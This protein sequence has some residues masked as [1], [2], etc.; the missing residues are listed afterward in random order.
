MRNLKQNKYRREA[1]EMARYNDNIRV[2]VIGHKNEAYVDSEAFHDVYD[3][4]FRKATE[5][6]KKQFMLYA[7]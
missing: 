4:R 1:R 2:V 7:L 3:F 5:R 6:D